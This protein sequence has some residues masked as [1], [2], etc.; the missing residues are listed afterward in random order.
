VLL[1]G[2]PLL[3]LAGSHALPQAGEWIALLLIAG[4]VAA[5]TVWVAH[6]HAR[7]PLW[8]WTWLGCL[9]LVIPHAPPNPL[10]GALAYLVV[11]LLLRNRNWLEATLALYPLPTFWAFR[12]ALASIEVR[13]AGWSTTA[14]LA[15]SVSMALAWISLLA[16]TLRTPSG[17]ARIVRA[18][19]SQGAL[20]LLNTLTVAAARFWPTYPSPYPF[21]LQYLLLVTLPYATFHAL[22]YVLFMMLTSLPALT[23]LIRDRMQHRQPPSRPVWSG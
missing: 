5:L 14:M 7:W 3:V 11:L 15:L 9:P 1:A 22:P 2:L 13:N 17:R 19:G 8:G 20:F 23:A 18:L 21:T 16:R 6:R 4:M 12:T 10:W